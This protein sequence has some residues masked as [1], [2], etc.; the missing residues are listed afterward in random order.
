M[1][2]KEAVNELTLDF[3]DPLSKQPIFKQSA[4]KVKK[5][6]DTHK[7]KK[8]DSIESIAAHYGVTTEDLSAANRLSIPYDIRMGTTIEDPLSVINTPL[9]PY[10]PYRK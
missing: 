9:Q 5:I 10:M 1:K 6:R 3:V 8:N 2:K 7:V 4:C